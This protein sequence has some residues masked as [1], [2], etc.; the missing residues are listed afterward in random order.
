[1]KKAFLIVMSMLLV[2]SLLG[3]AE[4]KAESETINNDV[5]TDAYFEGAKEVSL[6]G[7]SAPVSGE[8]MEHVINLLQTASLSELQEG[9]KV[10]GEGSTFLLV[11]SFEDGT[12]KTVHLSG[13]TVAPTSLDSANYLVESEEF[14]EQILEVF[15]VPEEVF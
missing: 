2:V 13:K 9:V 7:V 12:Y 6:M 5:F 1:M 8:K 3:C 15:D 14:I 10:E 11:I 4:K